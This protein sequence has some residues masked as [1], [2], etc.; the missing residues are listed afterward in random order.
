[1]GDAFAERGTWDPGYLN[2]TLG[3]LMIKKLRRDW[4]DGHPGASLREFHDAMMGIYDAARRLK[5]PYTPGDFRRMVLEMGEQPHTVD[6][7][8]G[9][10]PGSDAVEQIPVAGPEYVPPRE[11]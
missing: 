6:V 7:L 9:N 11:G 4:F 2:Y 10:V 1:M 5:P 8:E 3:K